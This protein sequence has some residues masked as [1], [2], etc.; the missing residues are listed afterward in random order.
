MVHS[1]LMR[2]YVR[3]FAI[4]FLT[5]GLMWAFLRGVDLADVWMA[6]RQ[7]RPDLLFLALL[8]I[9]ASYLVRI[10]RWQ[11]LL[12]PIGRV[13]LSSAARAT[14]IGFAANA[15]V[16]GRVG[17]VLRPYVLARREGLSGSAAFG[18][19]VLERLLDLL[20]IVLITV[21]AVAF[22][23]PSTRDEPLMEWLKTGALATGA[24]G[25]IAGGVVVVLARNPRHVGRLWTWCVDRAP[26][27]VGRVATAIAQHFLDGLAVLRSPWALAVSM[28][29]SVGVW[30]TVALSI[31]ASTAAF[32]IDVSFGGAVILTG[33]TAIGVS[34]PTPAG[35]GGY[36]AAYQLGVSALYGAD[37]DQA[38][39]AAL[40]GH[41]MAFGPVTVIGVI[42]MAQ[43]GLRLGALR[44]P[45]D[46]QTAGE[47]D[48]GVVKG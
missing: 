16:P 23:E 2:R 11:F 22:V 25:L 21:S 47:A 5:V 33:L 6:I 7:A 42:L 26:G 14:V 36:H 13:R 31:W 12:R 4:V 39:G 3:T 8:F 30:G 1:T 29:L 48:R 9:G 20:T 35:V 28:A 38:V 19:I 40:V 34:V 43:E 37:V 32:G 27:R 10:A 45:Q 24:M 41:I 18:T 44:P 17:E 46:D 15:L